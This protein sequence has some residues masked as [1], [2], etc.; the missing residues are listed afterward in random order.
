MVLDQGLAS[1]AQEIRE[2]Y[3]AV[4][5]R[6]MPSSMGR[7][8]EHIDGKPVARSDR[9]PLDGIE[10]RIRKCY[11]A[12]YMPWAGDMGRRGVPTAGL[13]CV[14]WL[15]LVVDIEMDGH[16]PAALDARYAWPHGTA[17]DVLRDALG[18][19]GDSGAETLPYGHTLWPLEGSRGYALIRRN[20]LI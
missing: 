14:T 2:I 15:Q 7:L 3:E 10:P 8:P 17:Q 20:P 1:A 5:G 13:D 4:L 18:R 11:V 19:Y 9:H 6:F 16:G 12:A